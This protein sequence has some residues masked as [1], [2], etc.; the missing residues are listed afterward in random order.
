MSRRNKDMCPVTPTGPRNCNCRE[1]PTARRVWRHAGFI[2]HASPGDGKVLLDLLPTLFVAEAAVRPCSGG[3]AVSPQFPISTCDL[4]RSERMF[5]VEMQRLGY[6]RFE[7]VR[8]ESGELLME[9]APTVIRSIKFGSST[10][11]RPKEVDGE[12]QLKAETAQLFQFVRGVDAGEILS[13]EVRGG[14]PFSMEIAESQDRESKNIR[15]KLAAETN[16]SQ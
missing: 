12:F 6:G 5:M 11:N 2:A 1:H 15:A 8:I 4:R 3:Y 13:L 10:I 14:I 7:S 16:K 9:P